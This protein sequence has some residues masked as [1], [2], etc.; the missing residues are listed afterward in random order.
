MPLN[1]VPAGY[2]TV[3]PYLVVKGAGALLDFM[4]KA[5]GATVREC[6]R[7]EDGSVMHA[8]A[9]IGDSAVM[10]G[11]AQ[12]TFGERPSTLYLYVA[13]VDAT[14]RAALSAGATSLMEPAVQFYG[15]R[16]GG[17]KDPFG[18]QWWMATRVE[19]VPPE[20]MARRAAEKAKKC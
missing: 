12:P 9:V 8:E 19:E 7:K 6:H 14:Y 2:H 3:T 16:S 13:D 10:V 18:N 11:E 17:V 20:E 15:D 4:G 5:F 1:P